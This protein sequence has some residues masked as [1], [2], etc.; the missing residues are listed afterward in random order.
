MILEVTLMQELAGQQIINRWNYVGSGTPIGVTMSQALITAM[1]GVWTPGSPGSFPASTIFGDLRPVQSSDVIFIQTVARSIEPGSDFYELPY[2]AGV[3]G[4]ASGG[5]LAPFVAF[6]FSTNRVTTAIRRGQKRFTGVPKPA[7]D[8]VG[9]IGSATLAALHSIAV[10]MTATLSYT[11]GGNSLTFVPTIVNKLLYH[12]SPGRDAY[13]YYDTDAEQ[14]L[15][16]A[17][18]FTW[19]EKFRVVSQ[20]SRQ[21]GRGK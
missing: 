18:G 14:M 19:T 7:V 2:P 1:G 11:D 8:D 17:Q 5:S 6:G 21:Y 9:N 4:A 13:K 20:T 10:D 16:I 15:H 3:L 12:P